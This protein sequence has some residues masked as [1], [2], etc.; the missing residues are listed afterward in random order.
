MNLVL[1]CLLVADVFSTR[2]GY[3]LVCLVLC[4]KNLAWL[5]AWLRHAGCQFRCI[6]T[7]LPSGWEPQIMAGQKFGLHFICSKGP[8]NCCQLSG[9]LSKSFFLWATFGSGTESSKVV[10]F[11]PSWGTPLGSKAFV[12]YCQEYLLFVLAEI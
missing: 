8:T 6:Q 7:V 10:F 1:G 11:V 3:V 9:K 12:Q 4:P 5:S 2:G